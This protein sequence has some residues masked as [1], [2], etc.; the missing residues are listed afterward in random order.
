MDIVLDDADKWQFMKSLFILNDTYSNENW[1]RETEDLPLFTRP[2][3]W[4]DREPLTDITAWTLMT[5]HFHILLHERKEGGIS[6]FMQRLCGSMSMGFNMKY[7]SKGSIFQG[8]YKAKTIDNDSYLRYLAFYIHIKNVLELYPGGLE[9]VLIDFDNAWDWALKYPF[10]GLQTYM[11]Q[12][13]SPIIN[14]KD[15]IM[16]SIHSQINKQEAY[17]MLHAYNSKHEDIWSDRLKELTLE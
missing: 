5:N 7:D 1:H 15:G 10:S 4:P 11:K 17:E 14:D 9:K 8:S 13:N 3:S 16:A 6:K 2:A 12:T